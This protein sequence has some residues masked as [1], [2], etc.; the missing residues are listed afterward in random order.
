LQRK[1]F[2]E[3]EQRVMY[4]ICLLCLVLNMDLFLFFLT[5]LAADASNMI[6]MTD[7]EKKRV[8]D[9]LKD[10]EAI[11]DIAEQMELVGHVFI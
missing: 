10:L 1:I 4:I 8:D 9:L 7:E 2:P 5:Q 11:P 6:A 3:L